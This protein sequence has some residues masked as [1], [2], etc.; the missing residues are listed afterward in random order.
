MAVRRVRL[1]GASEPSLFVFPQPEA[2]V[3]LA[4][5]GQDLRLHRAW[6][7]RERADALLA[8]IRATTTWTVER[9]EM[10]DRFVDVPREQA[11]FGDDRDRAFPPELGALRIELEA[12]AGTRFSYVLLNRYRDGADSVAWHN[13]GRRGHSIFAPRSIARASSR[14]ISITA[15]S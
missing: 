9:R 13:S 2:G 10:Y 6:F 12:F 15:I 7:A 8:T 11:W 5:S 1:R 3:E 4:N 14:S